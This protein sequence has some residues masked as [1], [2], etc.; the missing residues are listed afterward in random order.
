VTLL[1]YPYNDIGHLM[2]N[3][4]TPYWIGKDDHTVKINPLW[5]D[6]LSAD[7]NG[8]HLFMHRPQL[9]LSRMKN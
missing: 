9:S 3:L 2:R 8:D 4:C 1:D 7:F 6:P 5:C